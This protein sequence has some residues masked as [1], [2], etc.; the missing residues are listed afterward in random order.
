MHGPRFLRVGGTVHLAND[1]QGYLHALALIQDQKVL[2]YE[3]E[4]IRSDAHV[5]LALI[6]LLS[7][8]AVW[9]I[10]LATLISFL[11]ILELAL[12]ASHLLHRPSQTDPI[13]A[14]LLLLTST[15]LLILSTIVAIFTL[16]LVF[17]V[18]FGGHDAACNI[19]L[20]ISI[21]VVSCSKVG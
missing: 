15:F 17:L 13:E 20:I 7:V 12:A 5:C 4:Y 16:V 14:H 8:M 2:I 18:S 19:V 21:A 9:Q 10:F 11:A 6:R 3:Y 1:G